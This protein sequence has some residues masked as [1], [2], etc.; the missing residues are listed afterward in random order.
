MLP[1]PPTQVNIV[2]TVWFS[3]MLLYVFL[4]ISNIFI[5]IRRKNVQH[6][7]V[8]SGYCPFNWNL[9][10]KRNNQ[11]PN[12]I[13]FKVRCDFYTNH[14]KCEHHLLHHYLAKDQALLL[15]QPPLQCVY[16]WENTR[17]T[18]ELVTNQ[19]QIM[20]SID[21]IITHWSCYIPTNLKQKLICI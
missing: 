9:N 3:S 15:L 1:T 20:T 10:C 17:V 13:K 4:F 8:S 21:E 18:I 11:V 5:Y 19:I 14:C 12:S 7:L 2:Y 16:D 6:P